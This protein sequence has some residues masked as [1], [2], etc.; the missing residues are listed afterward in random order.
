[1]VTGEDK[2]YCFRQGTNGS[3]R[4]TVAYI[5][6]DLVE[7]NGMLRQCLHLFQAIYDTH[8]CQVNRDIAVPYHGP[9]V[10]R[11]ITLYT[12]RQVIVESRPIPLAIPSEYCPPSWSKR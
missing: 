6:T 4:K 11:L 1:M 7:E 5:V 2:C 12:P 9:I 3:G 8:C 10:L